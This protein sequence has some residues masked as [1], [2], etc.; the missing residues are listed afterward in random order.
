MSRRVCSYAVRALIGNAKNRAGRGTRK[1]ERV[2]F[3]AEIPCSA[4]SLGCVGFHHF[5]RSYAQDGGGASLR[6]AVT[7][8]MGR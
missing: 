7:R 3:A 8:V 1:A 6:F 2:A 4:Q 5:T